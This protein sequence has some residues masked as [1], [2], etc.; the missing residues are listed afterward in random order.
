MKSE[1]KQ[2]KKR[3]VV[4]MSGGVDSSVS[5]ALLQKQGY[6]VVGAT[7]KM[8]QKEYSE[9]TTRGACFGPGEKDDLLS[10]A[11]AAEIL[12]IQYEVFDLSAEYKEYVLKYFKDEYLAGRTPNPCV[13]CNQKIKFGYLVSK[14]SDA[15]ID[16][17]YFATGHYARTEFNQ[18]FGRYLLLRGCDEKKDQS[19][20]L[21]RLNQDQLK[22]VIFPLG[23][24]TKDQVRKMASELG[25]E[26][27]AKKEESQDFIEGGD[28]GEIIGEAGKKPGKIVDKNGKVLGEHDGLTN[29]TIGQ[30]KGI[31]IGGLAEPYYVINIDACKNQVVVGKK[32]EAFSETFEIR[33]ENWIAFESLTKEMEAKVKTR[34]QGELID[35]KIIPQIGK[36]TRIELKKPSFAVTAGQ[37]AVFYLGD[38]VLGGGIIV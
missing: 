1:T 19:Y 10:A 32:E 25:L 34:S 24:Y 8:W 3:I 2:V 13:M 27:F 28:Y 38:I 29:F 11:H 17:D 6:E 12:G 20:F 5:A 37:S 30:R 23:G 4:G 15:G 21:Y 31:N 18:E 14:I 36:N 7:M 16:F 35:C 9:I 26:E 22:K 33:D